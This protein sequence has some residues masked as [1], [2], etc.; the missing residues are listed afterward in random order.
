M[1]SADGRTGT[2]SLGVNMKIE[3]KKEM[4]EE[5]ELELLLHE[6]WNMSASGGEPTDF[7]RDVLKAWGD[8]EELRRLQG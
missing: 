8:D 7:V 1:S 5:Q 2:V 3:I 6:L 4:T